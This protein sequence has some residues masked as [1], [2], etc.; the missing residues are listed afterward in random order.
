MTI[1]NQMEAAIWKDAEAEVPVLRP[2]DA[3]SRL[4]GKDLGAGKEGGQEEKGAAEDGMVRW[5]H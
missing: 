3:K 1:A 2:P 4:T 5:H